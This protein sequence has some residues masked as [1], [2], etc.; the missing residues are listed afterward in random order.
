MRDS[1]A[2][3]LGEKPS[4]SACSLCHCW[5]VGSDIFHEMTLLWPI[6]GTISEMQLFISAH[7]YALSQNCMLSIT[8][9]LTVAAGLGA[10][11]L[12]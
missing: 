9:T 5:W 7:N 2:S 10:R 1:T 3:I 8:L 11:A 6:I 4:L 12:D